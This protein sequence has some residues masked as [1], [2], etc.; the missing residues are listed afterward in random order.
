[1]NKGKIIVFSAPSGSGKTTI[2]HYLMSQIKNLHFSVSAT[3]R[4]PR[5]NEVD[6]KDY[7]FLTPEDFRAKISS[8][9]FIEYE[10]VYAGKYYGTLKSEVEKQL[11]RGENVILDVDVK[12]GISIKQVYKDNALTVF[13]QP[14]S[15]ECLRRRLI[16]RGTDSIET[17]NNRIQKA[18]YEITF[19]HQFDKI[20]INDILE[21]A[22]K[23]A[24]TTV[25]EFIDQK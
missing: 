10:E 13:V 17:I 2:V 16:K 15:I 20:I 5:G 25:R 14:P 22:Q 8:N 9:D 12:G 21:E 24:L 1:M 4:L 3:S 7:Y 11:A 6:G 18:E 23:D 19:A